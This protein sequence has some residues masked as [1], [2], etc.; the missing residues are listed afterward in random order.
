MRSKDEV[1]TYARSIGLQTNK[2][3]LALKQLKFQLNQHLEHKKA[4]ILN[5]GLL[6]NVPG[7]PS[8]VSICFLVE[9]NTNFFVLDSSRKQIVRIDTTFDGIF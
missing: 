3:W 4:G 2:D 9:D 5:K 6:V 7:K 8:F 1:V